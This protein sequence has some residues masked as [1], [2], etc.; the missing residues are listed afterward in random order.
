MKVIKGVGDIDNKKVLILNGSPH[1]D[2][3]TAFII[4]QIKNKLEGEIE[5]IHA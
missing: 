5:E 4:N 2:G 3:D 1:K